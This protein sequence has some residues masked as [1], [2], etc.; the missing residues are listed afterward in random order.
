MSCATSLWSFLTP[1]PQIP[2]V[3]LT[4]LGKSHSDGKRL[5]QLDL[6]SKGQGHSK[7]LKTMPQGA[8]NMPST[9]KMSRHS[10]SYWCLT[11]LSNML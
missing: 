9:K 10:P 3:L 5:S 8:I 1:M 6:E 4:K 2:L 7:N 11:D